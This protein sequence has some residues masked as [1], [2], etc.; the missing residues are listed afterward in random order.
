MN[1][2]N[3]TDREPSP[4]C[5]KSLFLRVGEQFIMD[6]YLYITTL[7]I[8]FLLSVLWIV[9]L[10][11]KEI[12]K[13]FPPFKHD[14]QNSGISVGLKGDHIILMTIFLVLDYS[15]V[16]K[17]FEGNRAFSTSA[18]IIISVVLFGLIVYFYY[19]HYITTKELKEDTH[20]AYIT[21][22]TTSSI[23]V[24][25]LLL[26]LNLLSYIFLKSSII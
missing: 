22:R 19:N 6:Y 2:I 7:I 17:F 13:R 1:P 3:N 18:L 4:V 25:I 23:V 20:K 10:I 26:L 24:S 9:T 12:E 5:K 21:I 8:T 15:M 16:I 14:W 11:Y